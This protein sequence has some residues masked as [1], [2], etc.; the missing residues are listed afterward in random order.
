LDKCSEL[1]NLSL[2]AV[3]VVEAVPEVKKEYERMIES[4]MDLRTIREE[5]V[6]QY[7]SISELQQD[8]ILMYQ[9]CCRFNEGTEYFDY[10]KNIWENLNNVFVE[11][12][13]KSDVL[14]PRRWKT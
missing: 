5:R 11:S 1:D 14:L 7:E 12:C 3:P 13:E 6:M 10:A 2:F 9:N 4:P 8:L